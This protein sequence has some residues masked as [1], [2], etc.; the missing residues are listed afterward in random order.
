MI[1]HETAIPGPVV[2]DLERR[3]DERGYFARA[4][5]EKEFAAHGITTGFV[6][7]NMSVSRSKGT[8]RG[9]HLQFAP[10]R[11]AKLVR[12]VRGA[13]YDVAVDARPESPTFGKWV[14]VELTAESHR[15]IFVP[16]G[17]AHGFQTLADDSEAHYMVSAFYA[18]GAEGGIRY[19]DPEL[20]IAWPLPVSAMSEKDQKW[21]GIAALREARRNVA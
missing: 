13:L 19:D 12:C 2:I 4:W 7:A 16:E 3:G 20:G 17:F 8:L 1:F 14:G 15:M 9:L 11:E 5:C 6:Q 21:P 18:P 10:H